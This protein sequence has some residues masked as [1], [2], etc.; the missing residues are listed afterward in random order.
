MCKVNLKQISIEHHEIVVTLLKLS[1]AALISIHSICLVLLFNV[2]DTMWFIECL[3]IFMC[4]HLNLK[5]HLCVN[6]YT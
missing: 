4:R 5:R 2:T 6:L 3:L 1:D